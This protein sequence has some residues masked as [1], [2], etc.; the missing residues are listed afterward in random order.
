MSM[1][2]YWLK[3]FCP[4]KISRFPARC[5]IR[6]AKSS[7]PVTP[8]SALVATDRINSSLYVT[9]AAALREPSE[10]QIEA[11]QQRRLR[12]RLGKN[13]IVPAVGQRHIEFDVRAEMLD[14]L[15]A[16]DV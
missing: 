15:A 11:S 8:M 2:E 12:K 5:S 1:C 6:Y 7:N 10:P 14:D 4:A 16:D 9:A 3:V 13:L